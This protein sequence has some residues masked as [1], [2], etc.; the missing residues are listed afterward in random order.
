MRMQNKV[1]VIAGATGGLGRVVAREFAAQGA[2]LVLVGTNAERLAQL[3]TELKINLESYVTVI[4]DLTQSGAAQE[5]LGAAL[6]KFGRVD[7]LFNFIG[8]WIA[9]KPVPEVAPEEVE[10]MLAQH[11]WTS[12]NLAQVFIPHMLENHWGR[13]VVISTPGVGAPPAK[14]L[15]Y[16]TGKAAE[17]TLMLTLA[18]ELKHTGVTANVLRVRSI[19][20][21][22]KREREPSPK[23]A[24]WTTPEEIA[25]ALIYLCSDE[26][27]RV[28]GARIPLYGA[29]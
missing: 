25:A 18:E 28:N 1:T 7:I 27:N 11:F 14:S 22:H 29:P 16:T 23:N 12:F 9:G 5:V 4:A 21:E 13:Y 15:P 26:A 17:E 2:K 8:G 3:V 19:D 6:A 10:N 24:A 20:V